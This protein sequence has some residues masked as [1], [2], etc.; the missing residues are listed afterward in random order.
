LCSFTPGS[1]FICALLDEGLPSFPS[2]TS[3]FRP[4][5]P[6]INAPFSAL[7]KRRVTLIHQAGFLIFTELDSAGIDTMHRVLV[8]GLHWASPSAA[9]DKKSF[10]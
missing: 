2:F 6:K 10:H 9:L 3:V 4:P 7:R 5:L 8:V 1:P